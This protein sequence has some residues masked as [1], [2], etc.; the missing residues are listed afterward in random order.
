M[1]RFDILATDKETGYVSRY[2]GW[3]E[4]AESMARY[5]EEGWKGFKLIRVIP[6]TEERCTVK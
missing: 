4:S 1:Q 5:A 2:H 3:S 6:C